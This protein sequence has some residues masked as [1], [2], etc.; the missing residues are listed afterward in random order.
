MI[1][2]LNL[3]DILETGFMRITHRCGSTRF[4]YTLYPLLFGELTVGH[5]ANMLLFWELTLGHRANMLL[6]WELTVGHTANMLLFWK[7][8]LEHRANMQGCKI[9]RYCFV[10]DKAHTSKQHCIETGP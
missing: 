8:T 10:V 7:L 5:T 6:F 4:Q 1:L 9:M 3:T 2:Q